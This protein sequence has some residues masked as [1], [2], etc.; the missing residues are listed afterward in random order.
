MK[1]ILRAA[2][3][4]T[5]FLG[6]LEPHN[7]V[8]TGRDQLDDKVFNMRD[9][10][11]GLNIDF[12]S[13][14]AYSRAGFNPDALLDPKTLLETS[15]KV[16][17]TFFKHFAHHNVSQEHGGWVYQHVGEQLSVNSPMSNMQ[18]QLTSDGAVA[19][20]FED[21]VRNTSQSTAVTLSRQV[22][23]LKMNMIA[24]RVATSILVWLITTIIIFTSVQRKYYGDMMR[25]IECIADIL[26]LI[27]G[28]DRLLAT[29]KEQGIDTIL[30]EDTILTRLGWFRDT[31]GMM[32]W[33]IEVVDSAQVRL[34]PIRLGPY[35][36]SIPATDGEEVHD[37]TSDS[38]IPSQEQLQE[39]PYNLGTTNTLVP[40][41]EDGKGREIKPPTKIL[42]SAP[43]AGY[44]NPDAVAQPNPR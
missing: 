20:K 42:P 38:V 15:Q 28:S 4:G 22:E 26:V 43:P 41:S 7:P 25:N 3:L 11:T 5:Y 16:F 6:S 24:F 33:R 19:P 1:S 23:V 2:S 37:P 17:S 30:K 9:N 39:Q 29:I 31:D 14:A 21:V 32:R 27:A 34:Q 40:E 13:Y 44:A 18:T 8:Q 10:T 36:T 35:Y 12:M